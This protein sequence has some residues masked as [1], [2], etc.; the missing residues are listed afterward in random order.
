MSDGDEAG[1]EKEARHA[2]QGPECG[3]ASDPNLQP[4]SAAPPPRESGAAGFEFSYTIALD[5]AGNCE[6]EPGKEHKEQGERVRAYSPGQAEAGEAGNQDTSIAPHKIL[7]YVGNDVY[8]ENENSN[9]SDIFK[10]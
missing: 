4:A 8:G 9:G 7:H 10:F 3:P 5:P 1:G 6:Y 2:E